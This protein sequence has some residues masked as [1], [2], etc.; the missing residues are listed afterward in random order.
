MQH[1]SQ[2]VINLILDMMH[3]DL[4]RIQKKP[5]IAAKDYL[6]EDSGIAGPE[7]WDNYLRRNQSVVVDLMHGMF[8]SS[9]YCPSC[10]NTFLAFDPFCVVSLPIPGARRVQEFPVFY[11]PYGIGRVP[12][13]VVLP[14]EDSDSIVDI[15]K[16]AAGRLGLE[17]ESFVI[18]ITTYY[19]KKLVSRKMT[20]GYIKS[21]ISPTSNA[22]YLML[23][24]IKPDLLC[25]S[26]K[27]SAD[28]VP[29][30]VAELE[31]TDYNAGMGMDSVIVPLIFGFFNEKSKRTEHTTY[32]RMLFLNK[33]MTAVQ[34]YREVFDYLK[35]YIK[36]I[37][38]TITRALPSPTPAVDS[39]NSNFPL[40]PDIN[41]QKLFQ[42]IFPETVLCEDKPEDLFAQY[43]TVNIVNNVLAPGLPNGCCVASTQAQP[44]AACPFC[45][46]IDCKN[47]PLPY[48]DDVTLETLLGKLTSERILVANG[49]LYD[50]QQSSREGIFE[51]EVVW[52]SRGRDLVQGRINKYDEPKAA[53]GGGR[54]SGPSRGVNIYDCFDQFIRQDMLDEENKWY[55]AKCKKRVQATKSMVL[56]R[57]PLILVIAL[58]RFKSFSCGMK[59]T[60]LVDFPVKGLDIAKYVEYNS[61]SISTTPDSPTS[62]DSQNSKRTRYDLFAVSNHYGG[63]GGGHYTAYALNAEYNK[64]FS[65]DDSHVSTLAAED[66][67]T[68]AAYVLF[69]RRQDVDPLNVRYD[70]IRQE[71]RA[72]PNGVG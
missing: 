5:Y 41:S 53:A 13:R 21:F 67:V 4:N 27:A 11:V 68:S 33:K 2:E 31:M 9:L 15:R 28:S 66:A 6:T 14:L 59:I 36:D 32:S 55:C 38:R 47:C 3:E 35:S 62:H 46:K 40:S 56:Y 22:Y 10:K 61:N 50:P 72:P 52:S 45:E 25:K 69:Y 18:G 34:I 8:K 51:L 58:K 26:P 42:H 20:T 12:L 71:P 37:D 44:P 30:S 19:M 54:A 24:Q 29:T 1:D 17:P 23:Y 49:Y 16:K 63:L 48:S 57:A 65:F 43:F 7:C 39:A 70:E 60:E 64:W